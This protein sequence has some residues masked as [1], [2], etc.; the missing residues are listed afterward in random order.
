MFFHEND[1]PVCERH[2]W[3][4]FCTGLMVYNENLENDVS[5][6]LQTHG[7]LIFCKEN[8]ATLKA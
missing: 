1:N 2:G 5:K 8:T 7:I 3:V 4:T 6:R